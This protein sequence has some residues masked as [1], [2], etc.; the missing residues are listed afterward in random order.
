MPSPVETE[1]APA[2][3]P[4]S[5]AEANPSAPTTTLKDAFAGAF[6]VGVAVNRSMITGQSFGRSAMM[7]R[8]DVALVK[9]QFNHVVAEKRYEVATNS[10]AGGH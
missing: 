2:T 1:V 6:R 9:Q 10:S 7:W 8:R 4:A 5:T 3:P